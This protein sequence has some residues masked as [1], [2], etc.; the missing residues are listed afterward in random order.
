MPRTMYTC[1]GL[2]TAYCSLLT[3]DYSLLTTHYCSRLPTHYS[4]LTTH[5][6]Q[7]GN[8]SRPF[9][10]RLSTANRMGTTQQQQSRASVAAGGRGSSGAPP[11]PL[12]RCMSTRAQ[13]ACP[14][15]GL[16]LE[17]LDVEHLLSAVE[18][19]RI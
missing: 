1:C 5:Y 4:L 8:A 14:A 10:S 17:M 13:L 9:M 19:E 6:S 11:P 2:L 12:R 15:F 16:L 3:T 18:L 7:V